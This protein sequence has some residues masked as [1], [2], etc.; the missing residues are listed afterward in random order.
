M[1]PSEAPWPPGLGEPVNIPPVFETSHQSD[2]PGR[3]GTFFGGFYDPARLEG[4]ADHEMKNSFC[5]QILFQIVVRFQTGGY[6]HL[7]YWR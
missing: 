3:P 4:V 7:A 1:M 5:P 6:D 2:T